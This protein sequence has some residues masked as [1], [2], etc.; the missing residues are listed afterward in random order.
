VR[1]VCPF[2]KGYIEKHSDEHGDLV[3]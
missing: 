3:I 2:V 1:A